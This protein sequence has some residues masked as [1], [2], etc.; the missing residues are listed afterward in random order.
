MNEI[1]FNDEEL[2]SLL[3]NEENEEKKVNL[4]V[5]EIFNNILMR[6]V[7]EKMFPLRAMAKIEKNNKLN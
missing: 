1:K 7:K 6:E 2:N 3:E 4:F 5:D